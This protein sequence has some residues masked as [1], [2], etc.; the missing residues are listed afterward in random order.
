MND[1]PGGVDDDTQLT[2]Q[3]VPPLPDEGFVRSAQ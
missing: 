3:Q 1:V 2:A